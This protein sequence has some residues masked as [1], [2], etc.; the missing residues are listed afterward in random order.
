MRKK[1]GQNFLIDARAR[2][3]L[4]DALPKEAGWGVWEIGPGI[5]AMTSG[6]L[7][8]GCQV[9]AFEIDEGFCKILHDFFDTNPNFTLIEGDVMK[10]WKEG[11]A[12]PAPTG[13]PGGAPVSCYLLGNLP[14]TIGAA[15]IADFIENQQF[16]QRQ[17]VMLQKETADRMLAKPGSK[18]YSSFS[19][20]CQSVYTIEPLLRLKGA[21][22]Y[23]EPHVES[24]AVTMTLKKDINLPASFYPL[25]RGLFAQRR[26]TVRN[27][28]NNFLKR[29]TEGTEN[30]EFLLEKAGLDGKLRAEDLSLEDFTALAKIVEKDYNSR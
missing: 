17:V 3:I 11:R 28:L 25:V 8:R 2:D 7:E 26:K 10:T 18:N 20:L 1:F 24:A 6:L 30:P 9:T 15:L 14:Y 4:I 21:S 5:G 22:F 29:T 16:F 19:V 27:N 13:T 12:R 23:P